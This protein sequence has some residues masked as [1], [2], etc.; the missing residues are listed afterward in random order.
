MIS[1]RYRSLGK[2]SKS[3]TGYGFKVQNIC[4]YP[5]NQSVFS[6]YRKLTNHMIPDGDERDSV[7]MIISIQFQKYRIPIQRQIFLVHADHKYPVS[8]RNVTNQ[9]S[10]FNQ[11]EWE[12]SL[13]DTG[14]WER[15]YNVQSDADSTFK[16][17]VR[18]HQMCSANTCRSLTTHFLVMIRD[19]EFSSSPSP[20]KSKI[21]VSNAIPN[22]FC[23]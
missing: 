7:S 8:H 18:F 19:S 9:G 23:P 10:K 22:P 21:P 3:T 16:S 13:S 2:T 1:P 4:P 5:S 6:E 17:F 15:C 14:R 11:I 12:W 20:P